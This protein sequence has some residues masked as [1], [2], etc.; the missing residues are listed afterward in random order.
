M[1]GQNAINF[2]ENGIKKNEE[3]DIKKKRTSEH[4]IH[5]PLAHTI[6]N[7]QYNNNKA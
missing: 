5:T 2:I 3:E 7:S 4:A 6:H 1:G